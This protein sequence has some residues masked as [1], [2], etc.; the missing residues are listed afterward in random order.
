MYLLKQIIVYLCLY[1][2][3]QMITNK[4]PTGKGKSPYNRVLRLVQAPAHNPGDGRHQVEQSCLRCHKTVY[5]QPTNSDKYTVYWTLNSCMHTFQEN[6]YG[7][8]M[9]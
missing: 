9:V 2:F 1:E 4:A 6:N 3:A 5:G 7:Y 8:T